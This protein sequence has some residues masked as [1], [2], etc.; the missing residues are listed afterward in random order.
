MRSQRLWTV[1]EREPIEGLLRAGE[2][3]NA[4]AHLVVRGW[5]LSIDGLL[6]NAEAT[7]SRF[8]YGGRPLSAISAEV[9]VGPWTLDAILGGTRLSTRSRYAAVPMGA[10]GGA[11]FVLLPSFVAPHYSVVLE[12]YTA[13]RAEELLGVLGPVLINPHHARRQL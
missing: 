11:G 5:P 10:L 6:R 8:S 9:T 12:P 2:S 3:L 7:R 13:D 4:S 1:A